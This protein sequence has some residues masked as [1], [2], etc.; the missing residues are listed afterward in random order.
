MIGM[1]CNL[2]ESFELSCFIT[3]SISLAWVYRFVNNA[4]LKNRET[5][6][7]LNM[8]ETREAEFKWIQEIQAKVTS[9]ENFQQLQNQLNLRDEDGILKCHGRLEYAEIAARPVLLPRDHVFAALA[10]KDAHRRV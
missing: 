7:V 2:N 9:C 10:I 5:C 4:R 1:V 8:E 3:Y 6:K